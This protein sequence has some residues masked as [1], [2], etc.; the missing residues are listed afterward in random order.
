MKWRTA[1]RYD[2]V[3][4][5]PFGREWFWF[6]YLPGNGVRHA[7]HLYVAFDAH[8]GDAELLQIKEHC[9]FDIESILEKQK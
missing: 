2:T 4:P 7:F 6:S 9:H 1:A 3:A 5:E 8:A